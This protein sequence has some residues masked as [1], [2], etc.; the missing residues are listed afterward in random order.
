MKTDAQIQKDILDELRWEPILNAAQIGVS[1]KN[2]IATLTGSVDSFRKKVAAE[3]AAKRVAGVKA[4]AEE[5]DVRIFK[6][7]DNSDTSVAEA[8]LNSLKWNTSVP[9]QRI[10]IKVED[11]WVTLEGEV[12][13]DY[14]RAAAHEALENLSGV[15]GITNNIK[16]KPAASVKDVKKEIIAAFHRSATLDAE[17]IHIEISGSKAILTGKVRSWAEKNDAAN[18]AWRA[19]GIT[20]VENKLVIES[21]VLTY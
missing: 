11:G 7:E 5:I 4:I 17:H 2:G 16:I 18:A 13:W 9:H 10:K 1:V 6:H 20:M 19:P 14:Q 3:S 15:K 21:P 12:E 8:V